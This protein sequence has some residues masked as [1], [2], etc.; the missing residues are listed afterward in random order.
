MIGSS[1][2]VTRT[3][4]ILSGGSPSI[5]LRMTSGRMT[6]RATQLPFTVVGSTG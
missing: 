6:C 1:A 3:S 2:A 5:N 4:I